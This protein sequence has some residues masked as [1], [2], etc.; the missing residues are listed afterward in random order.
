MGVRE[1]F[2]ELGQMV[3]PQPADPDCPGRL[4]AGPLSGEQPAGN[5]SEVA[6]TAPAVAPVTEIGTRSHPQL[7]GEPDW[8]LL[9]AADYAGQP[10]T[11]APVSELIYQGGSGC[12]WH[13]VGRKIVCAAGTSYC[14]GLLASRRR[15][16]HHYGRRA[17]DRPGGAAN[18]NARRAEER[19]PRE[20]HSCRYMPDS[21]R[22]LNLSGEIG[23]TK[24][25]LTSL[26]ADILAGK[27]DSETLHALDQ[28]VSQLD[29]AG[30]RSAELGHENPNAADRSPVPEIS[31]YRP[32]SGTATR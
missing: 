25:R 16:P 14:S 18:V 22:C 20:Y 27:N 8:S 5:C 30:F 3:Q 32:R 13:C 19:G 17:T 2:G 4:A 11:Q 1:M 28:A 6:D 21:T 23:L 12:R 15:L 10:A 7:A 31:A 9:H 29:L 24:N 26:R